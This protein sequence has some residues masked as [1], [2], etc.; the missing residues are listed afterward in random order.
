VR[1]KVIIELIMSLSAINYG[2][3]LKEIAA[4]PPAKLIFSKKLHLKKG[5]PSN[6][7]A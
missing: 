5:K 7:T 2:I 3:S 6:S 4:I 1:R